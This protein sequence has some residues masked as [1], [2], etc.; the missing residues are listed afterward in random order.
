MFAKL[1]ILGFD[2]LRAIS[3]DYKNKLQCMPALTTIYN[4]I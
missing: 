2:V 3:K 4:T 1:D